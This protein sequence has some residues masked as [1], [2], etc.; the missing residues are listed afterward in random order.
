MLPIE[1]FTLELTKIAFRATPK[2]R[3]K[4]M[5]Q[6]HFESADP[7]WN[8]FEK[9]LKLKSF[10][11]VV[12]GHPQADEK[13]KKYVDNF[14]GYLLSKKTTARVAGDSGKTY[15]V[16][17]LPGGRLGCSCGN[18]QYRRSVDGGDCKHITSIVGNGM[19]KLST[20]VQNSKIERKYKLGPFSFGEKMYSH[21][22][23][24]HDPV[25]LQHSV[26]R[27]RDKM[28]A[29]K[30]RAHSDYDSPRPWHFANVR[31][32]L[33]DAEKAG[34]SKKSDMVKLSFAKQAFLN[35]LAN[36]GGTFALQRSRMKRGADQ[37][38]ASKAVTQA[39]TQANLGQG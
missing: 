39:Y 16:K 37:A 35:D 24:D 34:I 21:D 20:G 30:I 33:K 9:N 4:T 13:L 17:E 27:L 22:Q 2:S 19:K 31:A 3:A 23:G 6:K 15:V 12:A 25:T 38:K 11:Q 28:P 10:Q 32:P 5:A 18:W 29:A 14:G 26:E 1:S 36:I 8:T 7:N